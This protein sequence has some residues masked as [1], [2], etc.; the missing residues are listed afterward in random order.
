MQADWAVGSEAG[1]QVGVFG[2]NR[3]GR[4]V[5]IAAPSGVGQ[6]EFSVSRGT[7]HRSYRPE[8]SGGTSAYA[9][10]FNRVP[11]G[12]AGL[13]GGG[14]AAVIVD[15][16]QHDLARDPLLPHRLQFVEIVGH[17]HFSGDAAFGRRRIAV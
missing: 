12:R 5:S 13:T 4:D 3:G 6:A 14:F 17:D 1:H 7:H 9:A 11:V 2:G 10:I 16:P 8:V 15:I